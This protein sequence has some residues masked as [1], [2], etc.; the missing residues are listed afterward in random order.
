MRNN[1]VMVFSYLVSG[2]SALI[3]AVYIASWL[4]RPAS[5]MPLLAQNDAT[6]NNSAPAI[7]VPDSPSASSVSVGRAESANDTFL[8]PYIYDT[9]E[10][11]RN[12]FRPFSL[13]DP[14]AYSSVVI[15]PSTPLE[16]YDLDELKL[17]GVLWD[18]KSPKA[19]FVDPK[20][21]VHVV[22]KDDRIGRRR[23]Y[24][25]VI[26]EGEVVVVET[27][28]FSGEPVYSTRVLKIER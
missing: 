15:G 5:T 19:M 22:S 20:N 23:G 3:F 4:V 21:E 2:A 11:R 12:P 13:I 9:R 14:N 10:G 27:T 8:E 25:A 7:A 28:T 1:V 17:T 6:Q 18:V 26:R 16:R 24:V